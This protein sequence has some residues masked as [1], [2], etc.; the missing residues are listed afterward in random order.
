MPKN[1]RPLT[2]GPPPRDPPTLDALDRALVGHLRRD[3]R[4]SNAALA[5]ATGI[6]ESTCLG[7]VRRLRER[8]V[9]TGYSAHVD[10]ALFGLPIQAMVALRLAGQDRGAV[11]AF[12]EHI[13]ALSG[14]LAVYNL[15]G[16]DDFL[17]HVA[18]S[19]PEALRA[20]VLDH[21]SSYPGV[22]HVQT[23]LIFRTHTG[24]AILPGS[25]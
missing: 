16:A 6:A 3:A 25:T 10:L 4:M 20:F 7:R 9:I 5:A 18:A 19:S 2:P 21:L 14:V 15:S 8:G 13:G 22:V 24:Q 11:D 17:V 23:S 1:A 12:G